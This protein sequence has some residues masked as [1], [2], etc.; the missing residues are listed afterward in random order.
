MSDENASAE[1]TD[2]RYPDTP[3]LWRYAVS[4]VL[5]IIAHKALRAAMNLEACDMFD[6]RVYR[7]HRNPV[8][9]CR[10]NKQSFP[11][12]EPSA[13][14]ELEYHERIQRRWMRVDGQ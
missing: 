11:A 7:S 5:R 9:S 6:L 3:G 13:V 4:D 10:W 2:K 12:L 8:F 14:A 1:S